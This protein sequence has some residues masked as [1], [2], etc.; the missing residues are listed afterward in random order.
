MSVMCINIQFTCWAWEFFRQEWIVPT[1][2]KI[3]ESVIKFCWCHMWSRNHLPSLS[4]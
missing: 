1:K 2:I 3:Y 4:T